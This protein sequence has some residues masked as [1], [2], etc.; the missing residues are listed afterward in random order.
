MKSNKIFIVGGGSAGWM[1]AA[2]LITQFPNKNITVI[3]SPNVPTVGVGEST[4]AQIN[5]WL[6]L[7]NIKD[8][9]FMRHTDASYKLSIRF[10]DF[11]K[12][13]DGGFHYPFG[14]VVENEKI[15]L[16]EMWFLKKYL[17]PETPITDYANSFYQNMALV[18]NNVL[19]RND[20]NEMP[21][22]DFENN[23]AYHFD[24]TKF[25]LW[26]KNNF[27]IPKGVKHILEDIKSIETNEDGISI[28]KQYTQS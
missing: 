20:D 1:A 8:E 28:F 13:N 3:E 4:L 19:F 16:K 14:P 18:N 24:A 26:L 21:E 9:D 12:K 23:V 7:L 2:T 11:Y 5:D 17:N 10:E 22:F 15:G 27:C 25:G 6:N